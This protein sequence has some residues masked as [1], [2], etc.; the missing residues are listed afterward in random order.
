[1]KDIS[2]D[3][4]TEITSSFIDGTATSEEI[5]RLLAADPKNWQAQAEAYAFSRALLNGDD[6]IATFA[7]VNL[8]DR[9]HN[10]IEQEDNQTSHQEALPNNNVI[11]L[12]SHQ[13]A[14][15]NSGEKSRWAKKTFANFAVAASVAFVVISGGSYLL[16]TNSS[17]TLPVQ[18]SINTPPVN[19]K[20]LQQVN[21][22]VENKR[23]QTYLRQHAEQSTMVTGQGMLPMARVVNYSIGQD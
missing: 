19:I 5:D 23:L 17:T 11:T 12:N 20:P 8:F 22:V 10:A 6:K 21:V 9:I 4:L 14:A 1:M 16:D 3:S 15:A 2:N 7:G 18:A 13:K